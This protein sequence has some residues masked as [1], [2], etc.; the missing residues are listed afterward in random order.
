MAAWWLKR[1]REIADRERQRS[2]RRSQALLPLEETSDDRPSP[3]GRS[4]QAD[5]PHIVSASDVSSSGNGE[6]TKD[7]A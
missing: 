3:V 4:P 2:A 1:R 6:Q 7:A 5:T